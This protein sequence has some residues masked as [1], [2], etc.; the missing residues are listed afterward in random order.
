MDT[1]KLYVSRQEEII[2]SKVMMDSMKLFNTLL[3]VNHFLINVHAYLFKFL[4]RKY[5]RGELKDE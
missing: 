1:E 3:A 5:K 4:E 2:E